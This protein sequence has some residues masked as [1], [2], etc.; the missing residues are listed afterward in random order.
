MIRRSAAVLC[1]VL[2]LL[3]LS[4][5][6]M[7]ETHGV[8]FSYV[9]PG[10]G[11]P[12]KMFPI[13]WDMRAAGEAYRG[14]CEDYGISGFDDPVHSLL[15]DATE[16]GFNTAMVRAELQN[17][18]MPGDYGSTDY[19]FEDVANGL[20]EAGIN[21]IVGGLWTN[22]NQTEHNDAVMSYLADYTEQ[23]ALMHPGDVIG[24]FGFDEPAVKYL[25]NPDHEKDWIQLA[26]DYRDICAE[27]IGLPFMSFISKYGAQ[28]GGTWQYYSDT[29]CVLN[30]FARHM[31]TIIF[32]F[33][34][35][36]NTRRR[37]ATFPV[38]TAEVLFCGATDLLPSPSPYYEA[39]CD[40]DELVTVTEE[41]GGYR[42]N[43]HS[44]SSAP[45]FE[46]LKMVPAWSADLG[47]RPTG[48]AFSDFRSCDIGNR[49]QGEHMPTGAVVL[50]DSLSPSGNE[51]VLAFDGSEPDM[52]SLADFPGSAGA[53]PLL[54]CVGQGMPPG[55]SISSGILGR[56]NTAVLGF[57]LTDTDESLAAVFERD[58]EE[59]FRLAAL[60]PFGS[61]SIAPS[62]VLWGRFWND[63]EPRGSLPPTPGGFI[64][65]DD[66]GRYVCVY[67]TTSGWKRAP[68]GMIPFFP[69][70]FGP[71][72]DPVSVFVSHEDRNEPPYTPGTDFVTA[73]FGGRQA[74][75]V[76]N[77]SDNTSVRL[78]NLRT[79]SLEAA[80]YGIV[81]ASSY[82]PDKSYGDVLLCS[83]EQGTLLR[84]E[85]TIA[86]CEENSLATMETINGAS[87][88]VLLPGARAVHTRRN[89]RSGL[90]LGPDG[91]CL[92]AAELFW[93]DY[94]PIRFER[95]AECF[96]VAMDMGIE[97]TLRQNCLFANV[98][99]YGRHAFSLPSYYPAP[100]TM[101]YMITT[102]IV[103]GCRGLCFY[104]LDLAAQSGNFTTD[105]HR[106]YPDLLQNWGPSRDLENIDM[107]GRVNDAVAILT[108]NQPGGGPDFP[109]ALIDDHYSV[110][111]EAGAVNCLIQEG[112]VIPQ[113]QDTTINFLAVEDRRDGT[114]LLMI[115]NDSRYHVPPQSGIW[116]PGRFDIDYDVDVAGGFSPATVRVPLSPASSNYL[117][118]E[119]DTET[120]ALDLTGMPPL[121]VSLLELE[122]TF[123]GHGPGGGTFLD[124][125]CYEG[126]AGARFKVSG[127]SR[128]KL[129]MYDLAGRLVRRIW[130]GESFPG[131]TEI[132]IERENLASGI[133]FLLL[134]FGSY[135][136]TRRVTLL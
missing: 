91:I 10:D 113:P 24:V 84:S 45:D 52:V 75:M 16:H 116:F 79:T 94:D 56:G 21:I 107:V 18:S 76:R 68:Q 93:D 112:G 53:A 131:V 83:T 19:I 125:W 119:D 49:S 134:R 123:D 46:E 7:W 109:A 133:Y 136:I 128:G 62:G 12:V 120:L 135:F 89:I 25:E 33:Y 28:V 43:I 37:Y 26:A 50:W 95:Y 106:T 34:P 129:L 118:E 30:R 6:N 1:A 27:E 32:D 115:C 60:I 77:R 132:A 108:G 98:Q 59:D 70:L 63:A 69:D 81:S 96:E 36:K 110:M 127:I 17:I 126:E 54:F 124:V 102:P 105:G 99:A 85:K 22:P 39:Y 8:D 13:I 44:L 111:T 38:D 92:T 122:P 71:N 51:I 100:D 14:F 97:A 104:A 82:R 41:H 66:M 47:F 67:P 90:A 48:A 103:R 4:G 101:L 31:D 114:I 130:A 64:L 9:R 15:V 74:R 29:T 2:A 58:T 55:P 65:Y 88:E 40:R 73:V 86:Y 80:G 42:L 57:Y 121:G 5:S 72:E 35:N 23:T 11:V 87:G 117:L 61:N 78:N 3:L 20:R